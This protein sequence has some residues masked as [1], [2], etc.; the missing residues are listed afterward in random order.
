MALG[1]AVVLLGGSNCYRLKSYRERGRM[2]ATARGCKKPIEIRDSDPVGARSC[3]GIV[4]SILLALVAVLPGCWAQPEPP[5]EPIRPVKIL[6]LEGGASVFN[7]EYP[8]I[9][10]AARSA[11]M[12]FEVAGRIIDFPVVEGDRIAK[13]GL[14]A[15]LDPRDFE[16][17]L[18]K[19]E[20]NANFLKVERDRHQSL[21]DQGV[22]S[23]QILDKSIKNY[24]I[25]LS[26]VA[27][28]KKAME[29]TELRAPFDGVVAI[30]LVKEFRN[31]R[32]KEQVVIFEDDSYMKIIV[33]LPEADYARLTPGLTLAE[34]NSR[35]DM[36]VVVTSIPD[37]EF[38]A[39]VTEAAS[40]AD[41]VTR[42]FRITLAF[43]VPKDVVVSSGMTA[44]AVASAEVVVGDGDADFMIPIQAARGNEAGNPFVW[45][46]DPA[47]MEVHRSPVTL[48]AVSG[49]MVRVLS[50]LNDGD[51][52][53]TSG[54]GELREGMRVRRFGI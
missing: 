10:E 20:A 22:D 33:S 38:P 9:I 34:R 6:K 1:C 28:A 42:T 3:R 30:K 11:R 25:A 45:S 16:E 32:A 39:H 35:A 5:P 14:I 41:P 17:A 40:A 48:G 47:T 49:A 46:L 44:R 50:G 21:F 24:Q 29:D 8:G 12:A 54:V 27:Q 36:R 2:A 19:H 53:A 37:R 18:A 13:G 51:E 15:S 43:E 7:V 31:V 52:I 26:S 4:G 23:R